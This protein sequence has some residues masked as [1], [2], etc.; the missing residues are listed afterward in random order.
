MWKLHYNI[1]D[2][3]QT[4]ILDQKYILNYLMFD[5]ILFQ[6]HCVI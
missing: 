5:G 6:L 2:D 4:R 1:T 3:L